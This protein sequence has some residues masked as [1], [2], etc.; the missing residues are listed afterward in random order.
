MYFPTV[1]EIERKNSFVEEMKSEFASSFSE[2]D[3]TLVRNVVYLECIY[4]YEESTGL[5]IYQDWNG[6]YYAVYFGHSV[7]VEDGNYQPESITEDFAI[8]AMIEMDDLLKEAS[9]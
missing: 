2:Y 6:D 8:E 5:A 3:L 1:D 9:S 7:M 4:G